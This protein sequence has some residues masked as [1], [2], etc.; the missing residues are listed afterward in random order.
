VR[1][2]ESEVT[3]RREKEELLPW[4]A[5]LL[6]YAAECVSWKLSLSGCD[7]PS[8]CIYCILSLSLIKWTSPMNVGDLPNHVKY[9]VSVLSLQWATIRTPPV[10]LRGSQNL[11]TLLSSRTRQ[12]KDILSHLFSRIETSINELMD[13]VVFKLLLF[14]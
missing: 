14:S 1:V 4:A 2:C 13:F 5:A 6:P 8:S 10:R 3:R 11:P 12:Q 9:C 7:P